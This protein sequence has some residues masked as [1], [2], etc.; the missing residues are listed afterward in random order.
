MMS[1][2]LWKYVCDF[3]KVIF[4][5]MIGALIIGGVIWFGGFV[6]DTPIPFPKMYRH[7]YIALLIVDL[8]VKVYGFFS[9]WVMLL[10]TM[11]RF[12]IPKKDATEALFKYKLHKKQGFD[13]WNIR[14]FKLN[15]SISR[16]L[17]N[18]FG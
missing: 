10:R 14:E 6:F 2:L 17:T 9:G 13:K 3:I 15:L 8:V 16:A 18:F 11:K 4:M 5:A 12:G 7:T 1:I